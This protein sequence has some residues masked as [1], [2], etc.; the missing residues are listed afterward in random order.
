ME[1]LFKI[2]KKTDFSLLRFNCNHL[3]IATV[4]FRKVY[5]ID[6]GGRGTKVHMKVAKVSYDG[7]NP[8]TLTTTGLTS[9]NYI[10]IDIDSQTLFW[11]DAS[12]TVRL[13]TSNPP[14]QTICDRFQILIYEVCAAILEV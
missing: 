6:L 10:S 8:D 1:N 3:I 9:P 14:F 11:T 2:L 4:H 7:S 13:N 5:W 12:G